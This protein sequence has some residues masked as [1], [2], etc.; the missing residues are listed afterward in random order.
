[1][2][3]DCHIASCHLGLCT[4]DAVTRIKW[5]INGREALTHRNV[6]DE[7]ASSYIEDW[8]LPTTFYVV[9]ETL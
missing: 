3:C 5:G 4:R 9:A 8:S 6:C 7:C 2:K 1:M